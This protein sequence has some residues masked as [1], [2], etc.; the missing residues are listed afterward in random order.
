MAKMKNIKNPPN[1]GIISIVSVENNANNNA[2]RTI[3]HFLT[4]LSAKYPKISIAIPDII[5]KIDVNTPKG[6]VSPPKPKY[7]EI[8]PKFG[9]I[10]LEIDE[11]R[12]MIIIKSNR[13]IFG[14]FLL[15]IKYVRFQDYKRMI[16]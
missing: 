6:K 3:I 7:R 16:D 10:I 2:P 1:P 9:G 5:V 4:N 14:R 12:A 13:D 11:I 15:V 8:G